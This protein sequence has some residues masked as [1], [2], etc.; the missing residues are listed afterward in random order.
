MNRRWLPGAMTLLVACGGRMQVDARLG[1]AV[2]EPP[3]PPPAATPAPVAVAV[4]PPVAEPRAAGAGDT[5]ASL[6]LRVATDSVADAAALDSLAKVQPSASLPELAID[7]RATWDLN[8]ASFADQPRV[9]YYLDYF[10]GRAHDRFQVWLER[11]ARFEGYARDQFLSRKLPGDFVYLALIESGFSPEAV[12]HSYAV[13]MWQFMWGTGKLY[14]LRVDPW[15]DERRDPLK[16]T[17]AAAHYLDDLSAHF[18]SHYLAAAAYNAGS[19]RVERGLGHIGP[20]TGVED[21]STGIAG[22]N[23]FFSLADTRMIRDETKNYVPQLIAAA[24][25]AKE[26]ARYG[27]DTVMNVMPFSRDSVI[28][29]G[30]TGL[31]LI[32]RLADTSLDALRDLNPHLLRAITPPGEAYP[33]RVPAGASERVSA[34]YA[35]LSPDERRAIVVYHVKAGETVTALAKHFGTTVDLIRAANRSARGRALA[36]GTTLYVPL[37]T[38]ISATLLREPDPPRTIRTVARTYIVR[39]GETVA[40]VAKRAGVSVATLRDE[41]HLTT[42]SVLH[43]GQRLLVHRTVI[44][45]VTG[46]G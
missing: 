14:G 2:P 40:I 23:A 15:L 19:G 21:D 33:V 28:V 11:M 29:D 18:G 45:P 7:T 4:A 17:D 9:K 10:T 34:A 20:T 13:G 42:K 38:T 30:G 27:F 3:P 26:P 5:A 43:T 36:P 39:S 16:S 25:I 12:S 1:S 22:D 24:I 37:N 31:D 8:V 41:N 46:R 6:Q 44:V 35:T 32:A